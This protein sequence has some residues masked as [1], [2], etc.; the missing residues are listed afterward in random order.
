LIKQFQNSAELKAQLLEILSKIPDGNVFRNELGNYRRPPPLPDIPAIW[1]SD[2][3]INGKVLVHGYDQPLIH[4]LEVVIQD[5]P[6][7]DE[8]GRNWAHR[9]FRELFNITLIYHDRRQ[10]IRPAQYMILKHFRSAG[11]WVKI[12]AADRHREQYR[13]QVY[14]STTIGDRY[15]D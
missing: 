11:E 7:L 4:A 6:D 14:N 9:N 12:G 8:V 15:Y 2:R 5:H 10:D 3:P 1:V 13:I